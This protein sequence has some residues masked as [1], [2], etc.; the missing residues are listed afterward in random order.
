MNIEQAND[1]Y[2]NFSDT[3]NDVSEFQ[4]GRYVDW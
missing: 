3:F 1:A 4:I 2:E